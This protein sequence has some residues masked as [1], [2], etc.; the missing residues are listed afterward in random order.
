MRVAPAVLVVAA[1]AC[2][3]PSASPSPAA[4]TTPPTASEAPAA[5]AS[6]A[7]AEP[8]AMAEGREAFG[9]HETDDTVALVKVEPEAG[10]T[11]EHARQRMTPSLEAGLRNDR[12]LVWFT[13]YRKDNDG[14][15]TVASYNV[16]VMV[17]TPLVG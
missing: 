4:I 15:W 1:M 11:P 17:A 16:G 13:N 6:S 9:V 5:K 12:R 14:P 10:E 7:N 8:L 3:R 2:G